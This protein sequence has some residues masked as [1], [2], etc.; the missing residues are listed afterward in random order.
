MHYND[1]MLSLGGLWIEL[2]KILSLK[3]WLYLLT[4]TIDT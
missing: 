4:K 2:I 3:Y 1:T